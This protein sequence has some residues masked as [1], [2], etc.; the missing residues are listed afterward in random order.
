MVENTAAASQKKIII[1][2]GSYGGVSTAHYLLKHVVPR[3]PD[4]TSYEV[5]IV[6]ASSHTMCRPACP[7]ALISDE[8]FP[9][10][11]L[12][13]NIPNVFKQYPKGSFRFIHGTATELDHT[14]RTVSIS[15][16]IGSTEKID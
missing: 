5:I 8:M 1:L 13:V 16:A 12:F 9:Q 10:A 4:K 2:G 7:R 3:L 15:L 6:S 11:K 14:N